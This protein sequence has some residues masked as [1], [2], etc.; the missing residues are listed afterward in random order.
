MIGYPA[1]RPDASQRIGDLERDLT[2]DELAKH[3]SAGRIDQ[4]EM[5]E[6]TSA[7]VT[8]RTRADLYDLLSDLPRPQRSSPAIPVAG[9]RP[10]RLADALVGFISVSAA[11]CLILLFF[12]ASFT[13]P[14]AA[15]F[16]FL[17]GLGGSVAMFGAWYFGRGAGL[18]RTCHCPYCRHP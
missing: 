14:P 6:R 18:T 2:C 16:V 3:F 5:D 12:G 7:A 8:A 1:H 4:L 15:L 11:I 13:Y 17:G 9:P 10:G